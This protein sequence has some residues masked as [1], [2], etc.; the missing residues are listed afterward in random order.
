M[1]F[2]VSI[3]NFSLSTNNSNCDIIVSLIIVLCPFLKILKYKLIIQLNYTQV[4]EQIASVT[5]IQMSKYSRSMFSQRE[6]NKLNRRADI[7]MLNYFGKT[8]AYGKV[9]LKSGPQIFPD[10]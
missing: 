2:K 6:L 8:Q 4:F 7:A 1:L 5:S 3:V 10:L 9:I